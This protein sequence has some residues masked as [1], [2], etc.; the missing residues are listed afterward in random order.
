MNWFSTTIEE[1]FSYT[2][3]EQRINDHQGDI[4]SQ[5]VFPAKDIQQGDLKIAMEEITSFS[6]DYPNKYYFTDIGLRNARLGFRQIDS[7][8]I[9]NYESAG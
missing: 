4:K 5:I 6:F 2:N 3:K 9:F 8:H 7:G 1:T